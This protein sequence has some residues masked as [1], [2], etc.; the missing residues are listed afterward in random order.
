MR[1]KNDLLLNVANSLV[2]HIVLLAASPGKLLYKLS[3]L[4][5]NRYTT[6]AIEKCNH[7]IEQHLVIQR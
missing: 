7:C 1:E 3:D 5:K 4:H 2:L 6:K